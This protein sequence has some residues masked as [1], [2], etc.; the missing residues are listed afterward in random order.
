VIPA[1]YLHP[2]KARLLLQLTLAAGA[3]RAQIAAAFAA[4]GRLTAGGGW[5]WP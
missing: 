1:G 4:E 2:Y 5:P 3:G